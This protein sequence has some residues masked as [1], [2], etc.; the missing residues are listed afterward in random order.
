MVAGMAKKQELLPGTL[1]LLILK[2]LSREPMHGYGIALSIKRI[3][4][5]VLTVEEGSL[6]PAL[7]RLLLQ[8]WVKAEW[9]MTETNRRARYYTLTPTGAKQLG[10]ELSQFQQMIAAIGRVLQDA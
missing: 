4:D 10:V 6:Y 7:Q 5:D 1:H 2:T 9:K 8:G 3:T